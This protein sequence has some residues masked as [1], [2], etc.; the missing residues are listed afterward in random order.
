[1]VVVVTDTHLSEHE[2]HIRAAVLPKA[3]VVKAVDLR[4]LTRL[5]VTTEQTNPARI[6]NLEQDAQL[7]AL[8]RIEATVNVVAW[9]GG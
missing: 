8:D 4:D 5:V 9:W 3:L 1:M 6:S 7:R 2:P